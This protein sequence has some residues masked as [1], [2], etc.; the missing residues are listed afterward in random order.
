[1]NMNQ[2]HAT[3][4]ILLEQTDDGHWMATQDDVSLT[5]RGSD[6][7]EAVAH[8]GELISD[9]VYSDPADTDGDPEPASVPR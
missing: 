2:P 4:L 8:Y 7:G 3:T 9:A 6:P 5:G 1:M